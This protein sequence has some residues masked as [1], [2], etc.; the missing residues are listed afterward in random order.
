LLNK[1]QGGKIFK[2][3]K[4]SHIFMQTDKYTWLLEA[5][6][7]SNAVAAFSITAF[8]DDFF[9]QGQRRSISNYKSQAASNT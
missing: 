1:T 3:T 5:S 4:V 2:G 6:E 7:E 9:F 8:S